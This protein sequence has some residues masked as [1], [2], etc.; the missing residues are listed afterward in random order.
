MNEHTE[1]TCAIT[2]TAISQYHC[3]IALLNAGLDI[4]ATSDLTALPVQAVRA[5]S[6]A[7]R[8][9]YCGALIV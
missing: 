1:L 2:E 7:A 5:L 9:E 6:D 3:A 8:G 4:N